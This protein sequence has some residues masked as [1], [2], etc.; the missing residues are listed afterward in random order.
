MTHYR[1][2]NTDVDMLKHLLEPSG[3]QAGVALQSRVAPPI[4][5]YYD[6]KLF[7]KGTKIGTKKKKTKT[8]HSKKIGLMRKSLNEEE[9]KSPQSNRRRRQRI[10]STK[11]NLVKQ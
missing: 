11:K 3:S 7:M 1:T 9:R 8:G 5:L 4:Q 10:N 6:R 2:S